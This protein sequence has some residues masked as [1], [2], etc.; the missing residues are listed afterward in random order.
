[1]LISGLLSGIDWEQL[2]DALIEADRRPVVQIRS[3]QAQA[4]SLKAAWNEIR[5][6]VTAVRDAVRS[7]KDRD[8]LGQHAVG[9]SDAQAVTATVRG[10]VLPGTYEVT[11]ERLAQAHAV[12]SGQFSGA[13][14]LT[15]TFR[16]SGDG[17]ATWVDIQVEAGDTVA[18]LA[19]KINDAFEAARATDTSFVGVRATVI[20][21]RLV[22]TR[23]ATGA[24]AIQVA[25]DTAL[26][27]DLGIL[28][29]GGGFAN[30]LRQ[31]ADARLTING[32]VV[33]SS[34]N[35]VTAVPGLA[36]ELHQADPGKTV[37]L[38]IQR[39]QEAV[40]DRINAFIT[41][42]NKLVQF[43]SAR[44][45]REGLLQGDTAAVTLLSSLRSRVG[46]TFTVNGQPVS[47]ASIG[48]RTEGTSPSLTFDAETFW[49]AVE[50]DPGR[51][52]DLLAA[53]AAALEG[54]LNAYVEGNGIIKARTDGLDARI[55][56]MDESIQRLEAR[57]ELRR[58]TLM[59]QYQALEALMAQL[60]AQGN[61][62][63]MQVQSLSGLSQRPAGR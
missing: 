1:M 61:W 45:A 9:S 35:Q 12:A 46:G 3:R 27:E 31:G 29:V 39:D 16:L 26:L 54:H 32:L 43:L 42:Y 24:Q 57:L 33:T 34:S 28:A 56:A 25:G 7:L 15:D 8:L 18:D 36:I 23:S 20:D 41:A 63:A 49:K 2:V 6:L 50:E 59:R 47:L 19:R 62:L 21:N 38:T 13:V 40:E 58:S 10:S 51:V 4:E 52:D 60:Q 22:L 37:T 17:G 55:K 44:T 14:G 48:V 11:V 30:E 53:A 5:N